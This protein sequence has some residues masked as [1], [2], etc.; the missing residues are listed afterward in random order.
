MKISEPNNW[1]E[2]HSEA[3]SNLVLLDFLCDPANDKVSLWRTTVPG[4]GHLI[5]EEASRTNASE[6]D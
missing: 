5:V 6:P 4:K 2:L 3:E 1:M